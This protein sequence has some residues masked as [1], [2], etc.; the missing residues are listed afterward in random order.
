VTEERF[1]AASARAVFPPDEWLQRGGR[2]VVPGGR[3]FLFLGET[4]WE[5]PVGWTAADDLQYAVGRGR[6]RLLAVT[7]A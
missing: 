6:H 1:E 4:P 3:V 5:P 7:S 2:M